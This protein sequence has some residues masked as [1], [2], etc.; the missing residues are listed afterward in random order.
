MQV[1]QPGLILGYHGTSL[2]IAEEII[3]GKGLNHLWPSQKDYDWLG[4]GIYFWENSRRR[5]EEWANERHPK[6]PAV[7]GA[8][9]QLG[10]CF[11]LLDQEFLDLAQDAACQVLARY[12]GEVQ[13]PINR[14]KAHRFDC[15]LME[16][17]KSSEPDRFG[18]PYDSARAAFLEGE[19]I[20]VHSDFKH[21]TH[22]Q[23]AVYNQNCIKGYF[24]PQMSS[25]STSSV[26]SA[27]EY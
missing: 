23:V 11:D 26:S 10:T 7:I 8:V 13:P 15:E 24:W 2:A 6:S 25:L 18:G 9:I 16:F 22:I 20:A 1:N 17:I 12:A 19:P 3:H 14:G 5:A 4:S 27:D 21:Q